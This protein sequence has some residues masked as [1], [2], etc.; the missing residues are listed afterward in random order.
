MTKNYFQKKQMGAAA[1]WDVATETGKIASAVLVPT[2]KTTEYAHAATQ[3]ARREGF[4]PSAKYR[5]TWPAMN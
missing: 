2:T 4:K 5:D 1:L 3:M